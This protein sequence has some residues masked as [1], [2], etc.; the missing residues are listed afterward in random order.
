MSSVLNFLRNYDFLKITQTVTEKQAMIYKKPH[1]T[2]GQ[3]GE[4]VLD[5]CLYNVKSGFTIPADIITYLFVS[6]FRQ[7]GCFLPLPPE[8]PV[9]ANPHDNAEF[10]H[11][12]IER[13]LWNWDPTLRKEIEEGIEC[14]FAEKWNIFQVVAEWCFAYAM[15]NLKKGN[16]FYKP[17]FLR[18]SECLADQR[19]NFVTIGP[20]YD[21]LHQKE[22]TMILNA[23]YRQTP[24]PTLS[25]AGKKVYQDLR[26]LSSLLQQGNTMYTQA[27]REYQTQKEEGTL[28]VLYSAE[29][30]LAPHNVSSTPPPIAPVVQ[31][32]ALPIAIPGASAPPMQVVESRESQRL[33]DIRFFHQ[34]VFGATNTQNR[35]SLIAAISK[36]LL[37][38]LANQTDCL[39]LTR[40]DAS[41]KFFVARIGVLRF[42]KEVFQKNQPNPLSMIARN[43]ALVKL[44]QE[45]RSLSDAEFK[46]IEEAIMNPPGNLTPVLGRKLQELSEFAY[47]LHR[48]EAFLQVYEALRIDLVA[49]N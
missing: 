32:I 2:W 19:T 26:A 13:A 14:S 44:G 45:F 30:I 33:K 4:K 23:L 11:N 48:K 35:Q 47:I 43:E 34:A 37:P 42:L 27:L 21:K 7:I 29:P 18:N 20:S 15:E 5:I 25:T 49:S 22:K 40:A 16:A 36:D 1:A 28:R 31:N 46:K 41:Y 38:P 10:I 9:F 39:S 24:M 3:C 12:A 8:P 17:T 6:T